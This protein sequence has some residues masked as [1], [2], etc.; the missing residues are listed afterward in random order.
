MEGLDAS[1]VSLSEIPDLNP[2]HRIDAEFFGKRA[3]AS[4]SKIREGE[5]T[6]I[7]QSCK[8]IQHPIEVK[9]EYDDTGLLTIMA[10]DVRSNRVDLSDPSFMPQE[11]LPT[12]G[13]NKLAGGDI[14]VTR[15]GAN[16]G[17]AAPWKN[18]SDAYACADILLVRAPTIANGYVSSFLES[19]FGK[20]LVL[21][22]GYGAGQPHISPPY[23]ANVLVPRFTRLEGEVDRAVTEAT[24][25]EETAGEILQAANYTLIDA[26][27]LANW[28]PPEPLSFEA[29]ASDV[30]AAGR[31]DAQYFRPLFE[32]VEQRLEATGGA[33]DLARILTVN[34]RGRQPLY[35]ES[36]LPVVN[37]KHVRTNKVILD[38]NRTATEAGSPVVISHGDVLINGTGVGT[39]GRAAAYLHHER[40][41]PDNHVTVLRTDEIDPVFLSAFLN[42]PLGQWQIERH[43][44]GSS[45][46]IE[47]YPA[48]IARIKVWDAPDS[49]QQRTR[50]SILSAFDAERR[51]KALLEAAK[52]AI[53]IAIEENESAAV[54]WL[55]ITM[56]AI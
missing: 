15:T 23:L 41:L 54:A 11:L 16:F 48:D 2:A 45:G 27:G 53:E 17:Q 25:L 19:R 14:L 32:E 30:L 35:D 6:S 47:L 51:S 50:K 22:A 31:L 52:R 13:R 42:S 21:R 37:S 10:K 28:K 46:Q 18:A 24:R 55:E 56:E 7:G 34:T 12:V 4:L 40:A 5:H 29:Q 9:R 44:K 36:G 26:L 33:V 38:D 49:I 1:I 20:P 39:I 8:R 3:L 43:I